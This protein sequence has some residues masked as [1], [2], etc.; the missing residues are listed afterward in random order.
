MRE[1]THERQKHERVEERKKFIYIERERDNE[2][3]GE[4][5]LS[6]NR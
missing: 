1:I 4:V 5:R 2:Q 3:R 6:K